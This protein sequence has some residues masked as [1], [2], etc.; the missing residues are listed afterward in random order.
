MQHVVTTLPRAARLKDQMV[1]SIL[2]SKAR[3][4]PRQASPRPAVR[5]MMTDRRHPS[6]P[7][8]DKDLR[9]NSL[10]MVGRLVPHVPRFW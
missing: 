3:P 6:L 1:V 8:T 5:L 7:S 10:R 9:H 4:G 2:A